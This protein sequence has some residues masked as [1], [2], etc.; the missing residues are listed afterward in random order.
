MSQ[1]LGVAWCSL[2]VVLWVVG[3]CY[4]VLYL[5][6]YSASLSICPAIAVSSLFD[7]Y[8]EFVLYKA[9]SPSVLS[10]FCYPV[11]TIW[12]L[13]VFSLCFLQM[14]VFVKGVGFLKDLLLARVQHASLCTQMLKHAGGW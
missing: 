1:I 14:R 4:S 8:I 13:S 2:R 7:Q 6:D 12:L 10:L 11:A 9:C 5:T 3:S